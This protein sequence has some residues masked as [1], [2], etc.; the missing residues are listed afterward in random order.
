M[1]QTATLL[2]EELGLLRGRDNSKL[3]NVQTHPVYNRFIWN[4]TR[5]I[6]GGEVAYALNY[7]IRNINGDVAGE[8]NEADAQG[9][10]PQ[11]HG[12]AWGH[13]LTAIKNYYRLLR[14]P[15]FTWVPRIEAVIV[16]G[17]PVSVDYLDERKFAAAAAARARTGAEIISLSFRD[18]YA[19]SPQKPWQTQPDTDVNRAW[20]LTDWS[21]RAGQGALFDWVVANALLPDVDPNPNHTGI[22]KIERANIRELPEIA[23]AYRQ[24]QE[25]ADQAD[26]GLNPLGLANNV[27]PFDIDPSAV[28]AGR[29]HFDQIN[30]RATEALRNAVAVFDHANASTQLLRRQADEA[31]DFQQRTLD[32]EADYNNR[33]IEIFGT[34]YTDDIG[35]TGT[36]PTG[37]AGPDIYHY[38]YV[39]S[40]EIRVGSSS[41]QSSI[42]LDLAE[43]DVL[44]DG[45]LAR[46]NRTVAFHFSSH[47]FGLEKPATWTGQRK[48][49]GEIQMARS[50]AIESIRRLERGLAEYESLIDRIED[51]AESFKAELKLNANQIR[52]RQ[53]QLDQIKDLNQEISDLRR[54]AA[55]V[56]TVAEL[57]QAG[58]L[59]VSEA[60]PDVVG[61]AVDALSAPKAVLRLAGRLGLIAASVVSQADEL[62][63]ADLQDEKNALAGLTDLDLFV[64]QTDFS[65]LERLR[66]L[67]QLVRGEPSARLELAALEESQKQSFARY[68]AALAR[69]LRLLEERTRFRQKTAAQIQ[70]YR[71]K[72]MAFRVFRSDALQKYRAQFDLAARYAYL[73]ARPT[74]T[75]PAWRRATAAVP[76]AP[77]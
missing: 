70:T 51:A 17:V 14:N 9:L 2:E 12:D 41:Q 47:G 13:Y 38:D 29:T 61:L 71:Y 43:L 54:R 10:Y 55:G 3:P 44:N 7:N 75:R 59:F 34:P 77:S 58:V 15:H 73:A 50:A 62:S 76:A 40:P 32:G 33:L 5:D 46:S 65:K 45:T 37:Y 36:Y 48:A 39:D 57:A 24:I 72:D 66:Q 30:E 6:N 21:S 25:Q 22:Q 16:G 42:Q 19:D 67:E 56:R 68:Q 11:G 27:V 64:T 23:E 31:N 52:I 4:F 18:T 74:T 69:G 60:M 28:A 49:P 53:G 20:S 1:N 35:P 63:A 26:Q 8:I